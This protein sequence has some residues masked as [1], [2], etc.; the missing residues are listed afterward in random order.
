[1][2]ISFKPKYPKVVKEDAGWTYSTE[3][4][5]WIKEGK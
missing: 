1:M 3:W 2:K 4:E 5:G